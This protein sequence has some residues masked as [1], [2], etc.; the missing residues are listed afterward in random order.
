[1]TLIVVLLGL[2]LE[3]IS[4]SFDDFR[5]AGWYRR[6][7]AWMS[8]R[9]GSFGAG[10][11]G[12]AAVLI[13]PLLLIWWIMGLIDGV[14][15]GLLELII[16]L[17]VFLLA[18]GPRDLEHDVDAYIE[19]RVRDDDERMWRAAEH[20]LHGELPEEPAERNRTVAESVFVQA[21]GRIFAVLFWFILL[22]PFGAVLYRLS[23]LL[24]ERDE[25]FAPFRE[26]AAKWRALLEWAPARLTAMAFALTGHFD[27]TLPVL[28]RLLM[29]G[30]PDVAASNQ[31]IL[32]EAGAAAANIESGVEPNMDSTA[33]D[34]LF[35]SV[36]NQITRALIVWV[37]I[38]ALMTIAGWAA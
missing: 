14:M 18:L 11:I 31:A 3:R 32:R 21:N 30:L 22:G 6:Y 10:A 25:E 17:A 35:Q 5:E 1:M 27:D 36:M 24:A 12:I 15:L 19:A 8:E 33:V 26:A 29:S 9:L 34:L 13:P 20:L 28:R 23:S 4:G 2:F 37:T 7:A 16:G 38:L